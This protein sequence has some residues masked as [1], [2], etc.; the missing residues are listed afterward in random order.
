M[1]MARADAHF[2]SLVSA[3]AAPAAPRASAEVAPHNNKDNF[4]IIV[5][6]SG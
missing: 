5:P 2:G 1:R 4:V 3:L 6:R